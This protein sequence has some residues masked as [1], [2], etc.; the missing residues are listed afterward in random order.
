M[1]IKVKDRE[2]NIIRGGSAQQ[3]RR[4]FFVQRNRKSH[5]PLVWVNT[6][7]NRNATATRN[8]WEHQGSPQRHRIST[9]FNA[10]DGRSTRFL[11]HGIGSSPWNTYYDR[12]THFSNRRERYAYDDDLTRDWRQ[13][14]NTSHPQSG[15]VFTNRAFLKDTY[16]DY[17]NPF[18][19]LNEIWCE[20]NQVNCNCNISFRQ[21]HNNSK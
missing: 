5:A 10:G 1:L 7:F 11:S 9:E 16:H 13:L 2:I 8:A 18:S 4:P 6:E 12:G 15:N 21:Y 14:W 17:N 20:C 3:N 19:T